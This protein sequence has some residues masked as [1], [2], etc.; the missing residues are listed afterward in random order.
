MI[1]FISAGCLRNA[2][3]FRHQNMEKNI[4]SRRSI[5]PINHNERNKYMELYFKNPAKCW[6]E[7][8]PLGNGRMGAVIHGAL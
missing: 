1:S 5:I 3:E 7:G 4:I 8:F 2:W 6:L